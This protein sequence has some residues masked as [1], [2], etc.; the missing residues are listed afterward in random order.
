[1]DGTPAESERA[2]TRFIMNKITTLRQ[3]LLR[4]GKNPLPIR[5]HFAPLDAPLTF[6]RRER[7]D[8]FTCTRVLRERQLQL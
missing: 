5:G 2:C 8:L 7:K 6:V 3:T 1:M 4:K